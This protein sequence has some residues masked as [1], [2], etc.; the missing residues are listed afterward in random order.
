MPSRQSSRQ[1][2]YRLATLIKILIS[3]EALNWGQQK[4][5]AKGPC[6]GEQMMFRTIF[7]MAAVMACIVAA[8]TPPAMADETGLVGLHS[9]VRVGHRSCFAGH[10][11]Y[12]S[13]TGTTRRLAMRDMIAG[14]SSFT[15]W[16]YGSDWGHYSR[17][18][19]KR[20][21]CVH[22][23]N[24]SWS[25]S[26]TARPCRHARGRYVRRARRARRHLVRHRIARHR[27]RHKHR[28][29]RYRAVR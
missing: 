12:A 1:Q 18:A 27:I 22:D 6:I 25:C 28:I 11:H 19:D 7:K 10:E 16:E 20:V 5:P 14:W 2:L 3:I 26:G 23:G 17:A 29:R 8:M 15:A 24:R 13:G 9:Q 4:G 21:S